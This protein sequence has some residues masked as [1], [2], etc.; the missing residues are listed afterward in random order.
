MRT[1]PTWSDTGDY[2]HTETLLVELTAPA[3]YA[4]TPTRVQFHSDIGRVSSSNTAHSIAAQNAATI[5]Q[6]MNSPQA[7]AGSVSEC[8][9]GGDPAAA[10]GYSSGS[11]VGYR[12]YVVHKN[13]L[14]E[15]R[16]FGAAGIGDQAIQDV[17]GMMGSIVW[18][19]W[20]NPGEA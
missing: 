11:E 12:L 10:F 6:Y 9:I 16:L 20:N 15:I 14:F 18:G 2:S 3:D 19:S 5:I 17:R 7:V 4:H 1:A 8:A 13:Y